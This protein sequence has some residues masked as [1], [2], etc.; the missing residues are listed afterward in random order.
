MCTILPATKTLA[1]IFPAMSAAPSTTNR[2]AAGSLAD[3]GSTAA[4]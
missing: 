2:R 4:Y 1:V 3:S